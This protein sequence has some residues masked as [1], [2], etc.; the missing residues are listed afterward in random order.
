[1]TMT[2]I[3]FDLGPSWMDPIRAF[4]KEGELPIDKLA[5][6]KLKFN[7]ARHVLTNGILYKRGIMAGLQRC[8]H[9]TEV[10]E[11]IEEIHEGSCG[12]HV[13]GR[14]L[15]QRVMTQGYYCTIMR[16][17]CIAC[18]KRC[19]KCQRFSSIRRTPQALLTPITSPGH[20]PCGELIWLDHFQRPRKIQVPR[21]RS[22]LFY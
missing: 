6:K 18:A 9:P 12:A 16:A 20:L 1:M 22:G 13:A 21:R 14:T 7:A 3:T 15:L 5:A 11:L 8:V 19:D 10:K 2:F 17:D 4:I